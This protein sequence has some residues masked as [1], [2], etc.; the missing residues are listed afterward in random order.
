[1]GGIMICNKC[2]SGI[3]YE[4]KLYGKRIYCA[5]LKFN[6]DNEVF[7]CEAFKEY[8][9][10]TEEDNTVIENIKKKNLISKIFK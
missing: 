1:V 9:P 5:S 8:I 2:E 6:I 3:K 7:K 10:A 4:M